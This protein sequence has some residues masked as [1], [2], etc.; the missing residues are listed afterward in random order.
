[1]AFG[2]D[3]AGCHMNVVIWGLSV[4]EVTG[5]ASGRGVVW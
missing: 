1:M 5:Y 4:H 2:G 3:Y